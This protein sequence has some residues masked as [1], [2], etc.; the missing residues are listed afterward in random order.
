MPT[1]VVP[2]LVRI[3][4]KPN[5][6]HDYPDWTQLP[7]QVIGGQRHEDHQIQKW[8]Y[9]KVSGHDD[10]N[11]TVDFLDSPKGNQLG[12]MLVTDQYAQEAITLFP[13]VS[14]ITEAQLEQFW[15]TRAT[16]FLDDFKYDLEYLQTLE[17]EW[18]LRDI[19]KDAPGKLLVEAQIADALDVTKDDKKGKKK[20]KK[21]LWADAK[22]TLDITIK[23]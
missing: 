8:M 15:D 23:P 9:D 11:P 21:K 4:L 22:L 6:H 16:V 19:L 2:I 14:I 17:V 18:R 13:A 7:L 5:G 3:G 10:H 1:E 12:V 20:D